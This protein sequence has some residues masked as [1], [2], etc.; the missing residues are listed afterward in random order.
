MIFFK[1]FFKR[2]DASYFQEFNH[3]Q[4]GR[5]CS[6]NSHCN[7]KKNCI[8]NQDYH[9]D[10]YGHCVRKCEMRSRQRQSSWMLLSYNTANDPCKDVKCGFN[11]RCVAKLHAPV[12][13]CQCT[14]GSIYIPYLKSCIWI[15][16]LSKK[17]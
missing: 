17:M 15:H 14:F 12:G 6:E 9:R 1:H 7:E 16:L 10:P 5:I 13:R 2:C 4:N 11:Q 3:C 8:C